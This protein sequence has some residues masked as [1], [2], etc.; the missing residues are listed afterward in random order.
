MKYG[1]NFKNWLEN[2][3]AYEKAFA[4]RDITQKANVAKL[5][6]INGNLIKYKQGSFATLYQH[7]K[8][9]DRLIKITSHKEDVLNLVRAQNLNSNNVIKLFDWENKQKVKE[10]PNLNSLA[11][12]V[13]KID[14]PAMIYT[15]SDFY[16]LSLNGKFELA[17][18]WIMQG[19]NEKQKR[20]M[21][22]YQLNNDQ[23][24]YKLHD[25]FKT[26]Q[27]LKKFYRIELSDFED[28]IIDNG[29]RYVIIDMGF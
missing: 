17:G 23:E 5:L 3:A 4:Q 27:S 13:E 6:G 1:L 21:D 2:L 9:Q 22:R 10:L 28:N 11:I 14:G 25:L 12:I 18:D 20:I 24:H 15:T 26:L 19:G 16:E 29:S 7:P 8:K